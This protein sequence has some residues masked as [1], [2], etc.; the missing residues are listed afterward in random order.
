MIRSENNPLTKLAGFDKLPEDKC[1]LVF[2]GYNQ[3]L[4]A[5]QNFKVNKRLL[6]EVDRSIS[7]YSN[8]HPNMEDN[9]LLEEEKNTTFNMMQENEGGEE[10]QEPLLTL[11]QTASEETTNNIFYDEAE[12]KEKFEEELSG[13]TSEDFV[14]DLA[15]SLK[16]DCRMIST[17]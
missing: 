14:V 17:N 1:T 15:I 11:N 2:E 13:Y 6:N 9:E 3:F 7:H 5:K 8:S 16:F 4:N 10:T 12:L